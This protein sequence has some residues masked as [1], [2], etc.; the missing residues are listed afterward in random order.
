MAS[1]L[2]LPPAIVG[3]LVGRAHDDLIRV[4]ELLSEYPAAVNAAWDWG[5]GDWETPLGAAAHAGRKDIAEL[6]LARG[7]RLDIFAAATLGKLAILRAMLHDHPETLHATGPHGISLLA[8]AEA[9]KDR[10]TVAFLKS[11][12]HPV[13]KISARP[14]PA[15]S[16]PSKL[17]RRKAA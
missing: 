10:E 13:K 8:H 6:L 5:N 1:I 12:L 9:G 15:K 3:E 4:K 7:A 11:L 2:P 16:R 17:K 14:A